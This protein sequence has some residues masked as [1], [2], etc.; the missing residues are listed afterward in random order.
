MHPCRPTLCSWRLNS[1][2]FISLRHFV[3]FQF[4]WDDDMV[5]QKL[6]ICTILSFKGPEK[7]SNTETWI[8]SFYQTTTDILKIAEKKQQRL[9]SQKRIVN[10]RL[11]KMSENNTCPPQKKNKNKHQIQQINSTSKQK[12]HTKEKRVKK[13]HWRQFWGLVK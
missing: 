3:L 12:T 4:S 1:R 9:K 8:T 10:N 2:K 5:I 11:N 13:C 6:L 7:A